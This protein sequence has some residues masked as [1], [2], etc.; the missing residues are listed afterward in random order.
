MNAGSSVRL[1][2]R[3]IPAILALLS[4]WG[5]AG[6]WPML[7][8]G[9]PQWTRV[10]PMPVALLAAL[11]WWIFFSR[12]RR[13]TQKLIFLG[14]TAGLI[15]GF[16]RDAGGG[17]RRI[18]APDAQT[19]RI[20]QWTQA[21]DTPSQSV[22]AELLKED[23]PH[24]LVLTRPTLT[25]MDRRQRR[26]LQLTYTLVEN[27]TYI[28]SRYPLQK[29]EDPL[30]PDT[31]TVLV[32]IA[33]PQGPVQLLA[34]DAGEHPISSAAVAA[35]DSWLSARPARVPLIIAGGQNRSRTDAIWKPL[36]AFLRPA[37]EVAGYG[38][39]Y[40]W[41]SPLPLYTRDDIWVTSNLDVIAA[42]YRSS[43]HSPH[44]RQR[45]ALTWPE[46]P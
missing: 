38:W 32:E 11:L 31:H 46:L 8:A 36:R 35:L 6:W 37:Y 18:G 7:A 13:R 21:T 34:L 15:L 12:N 43:P 10:M 4:L 33:A 44:L 3:I 40:S 42:A 9:A 1:H 16:W 41:P 27:Q 22:L 25:Q 29:R 5:L 14:I 24:I 20:T 39:P 19:L 2:P 26:Q 28:L 30:F 17:S 45:I 23:P